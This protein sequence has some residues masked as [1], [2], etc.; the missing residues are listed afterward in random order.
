MGFRC[1]LKRS[2]FRR[3]RSF[4]IHTL[5]SSVD[6]EGFVSEELKPLSE[7]SFPDIEKLDWDLMRKAGVNLEQVKTEII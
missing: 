2:G 3:S 1:I 7:Q 6:S 4:P 5:C